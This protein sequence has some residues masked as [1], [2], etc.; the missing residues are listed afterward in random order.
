MTSIPAIVLVRTTSTR[1]P[2]KCLLPLGEYTVI[3][4]V[5][6]RLK[7]F[8]FTPIIATSSKP[9]DDHFEQLCK[10][11]HTSL[12]RGELDNKIKRIVDA[13]TQFD[14]ENILLI[15]AD[16]PFF[17][18]DANKDSFAYLSKGHNIVLPPTHYY[19]GSVGYS[20]KKTVLERAME[21]Y[22][23]SQSEMLE[24]FI[25]DLKGGSVLRMDAPTNGMETIRLTLDYQEDYELIQKVVQHGGHFATASDI[26]TLFNQNPSLFLI[27]EFRQQEWHNNQQAIKKAEERNKLS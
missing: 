18:P 24:S 8:G 2:K 12:F 17:D 19:W 22:N 1:L 7:H 3:E 6:Q 16:D 25:L 9:D 23:T 15:D 26:Q 14:L 21:R 20:I 11:T 10:R 13:A 27:N 5:I 4:H